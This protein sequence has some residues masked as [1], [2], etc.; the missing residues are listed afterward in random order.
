VATLLTRLGC[1]GLAASEHAGS[2]LMCLEAVA[3]LVR[4]AGAAHHLP[5]V[6]EGIA[7]LVGAPAFQF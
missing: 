7:A 1:G 5:L 2:A 6:T 3:G 4:V